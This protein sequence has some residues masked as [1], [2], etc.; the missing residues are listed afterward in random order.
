MTD[1]ILTVIVPVYNK[2]DLLRQCMD[3]FA[4]EEFGGALEVIVIDDGSTDSSYSIILEYAK[5]FPQ[6]FFPV[7]KE[8]T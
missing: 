6:I 7:C 4:Y 1:I 5:R 8:Y 2:E 3:S